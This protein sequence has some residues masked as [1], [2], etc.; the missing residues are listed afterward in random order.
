MYSWDRNSAVCYTYLEDVAGLKLDPRKYATN[1]FTS[2]RWFIRG[3]TLQE[4]LASENL[5]FYSQSWE[6][7]GTKED[8]IERVSLIT[9]IHQ[10]VLR[11]DGTAKR[12]SVAKKMHWASKRVTTRT[13]DQAYCLMGIFGVHM[14]L[15]YGEGSR[16]F[17][18]LQLEIIKMSSDD[19]IFAFQR[20]SHLEAG[21]AHQLSDFT[22]SGGIRRGVR[23][24]PYS[25]TNI[26]LQIHGRIIGGNASCGGECTIFAAGGTECGHE[27]CYFV[28]KSLCEAHDGCIN[29]IG[30]RLQPINVEEK[31]LARLAAFDLK[32]IS[33]EDFVTP[34]SF[35]G[36]ITI[37]LSGMSEAK[38]NRTSIG[39]SQP[40]LY[41]WL[42]FSF[43]YHPLTFAQPRLCS[44]TF[45]TQQIPSTYLQFFVAAGPSA[46]HLLQKIVRNSQHV[47]TSRDPRR[48]A[49][50][51]CSSTHSPRVYVTPL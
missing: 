43:S 7:L 11:N 18:R 4:L 22:S 1:E 26:G 19:S 14:P 21:L 15:L 42:G 8:L 48:L 39:A 44:T 41:A 25:V 2:C 28:L 33:A 10:S 13:E 29:P 30:I 6:F 17:Q 24:Q 49:E 20:S 31:I 45:T 9:G 47:R 32:T 12:I 34:E 5:C 36:W 46:L 37:V 16:A 27:A 23:R 40:S 50:N 35:Y 38:E 51:L 3:W